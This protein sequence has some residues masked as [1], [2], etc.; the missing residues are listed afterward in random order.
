MQKNGEIR[1]GW[2]HTCQTAGSATKDWDYLKQIIRF[3]FRTVLSLS[4]LWPSCHL[5]P[6]AMSFPAVPVANTW[7]PQV[8]RTLHCCAWETLDCSRSWQP[9]RS[10][11]TATSR[12][13]MA[14]LWRSAMPDI[15]VAI[16]Y[17]M[18]KA[19][20]KR[21]KSAEFL[22]WCVKQIQVS[23]KKWTS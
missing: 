8:P 5:Q 16:A 14:K 21:Q 12:L 2:T 6:L 4:A 10:Y 19:C 9:Q 1:C 13:T 17:T 3:Y 7:H 23:F 15:D 20:R 22:F 11:M 18:G